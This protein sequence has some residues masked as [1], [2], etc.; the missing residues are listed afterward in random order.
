MFVVTAVL[1][2][3]LTVALAGSAAGKLTR[4]QQIMTT[5]RGVGVQD[6]QVPVLAGIEIVGALGLVVGLFVGWIGVVAAV[7]VLAYFALAAG[8]HVRAD[9]TGNL[10]P[11]GGLAVLSLVV[12][13]LRVVTL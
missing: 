11:A 5:L 10:A 9:D 7:G 3:L 1:A 6:K 4:S 2:L 12:L 8:A 13:V